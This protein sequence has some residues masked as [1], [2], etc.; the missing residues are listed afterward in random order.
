MYMWVFYKF[1]S[2]TSG[3]GRLN[4]RII[5]YE[6]KGVDIRRGRIFGRG[7]LSAVYGI[8]NSLPK[9][10]IYCLKRKLQFSQKHC[11]IGLILSNSTL[12]N[13]PTVFVRKIETVIQFYSYLCNIVSWIGNQ[14]KCYLYRKYYQYRKWN[15]LKLLPNTTTISDWYIWKAVCTFIP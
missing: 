7:E 5:V 9:L 13:E 11:K 10:V 12:K 6:F 14:N 4:G 3:R 15:L 8:G 1:T 2:R